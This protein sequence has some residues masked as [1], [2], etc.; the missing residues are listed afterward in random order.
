VSE[1]FICYRR[2]DSSGHA[3]RLLD[4]MLQE[5]GP[6]KVF[7]DVVGIEPGVNFKAHIEEAIGAC[8]VVIV[9]IGTDWLSAADSA[10]EPRLR[11]PRD[12]LRLELATALRANKR[13]IPALV[14][15]ARVPDS[16]DL[17]ED[18]RTLADLS[19]IELSDTRWDYDVSV[20]VSAIKRI[21]HAQPPVPGV[22]AESTP[23]DL[24]APPQDPSLRTYRLEAEAR[25]ALA[26]GV[27]AV[28][29]ALDG[30]LGPRGQF[31]ILR[32]GAGGKSTRR[33]LAIVSAI[34]LGDPVRQ[35]G[36]EL[37]REMA[38]EMQSAAGGGVKTAIVLAREL[39]TRGVEAE[40]DG[41][42]RPRLL[43][44]LRDAVDL[45]AA[46]LADDALQIDDP[47]TVKRIVAAI[48]A[49]DDGGAIAAA[50]ADVIEK[51]GR[52]GVVFVEESDGPGVEVELTEGMRFQSGYVSPYMVTDEERMEAVLDDPYVLI[53]SAKTT[54]VRDLLPVLEAVLALGKPLLI[55]AEDVEGESL[56]TL[57]VNKLRGTFTSVAV[58]A[59]GFGEHRARMLEDIALLTGAEIVGE[60]HAVKLEDTTISQLGRA[61]HVVVAKDATTIVGGAGNRA[62]IAIRTLKIMGELK[63]TGSD[64]EREWLEER[65][66]KLSGGVAIV[67]VGAAT[68]AKL[69]DRKARYEEAIEAATAALDQGVLPGGGAALVHAGRAI[70]LQRY[71][72]P[73]EQ[74]GARIVLEALNAPLGQIASNAGFDAG[75]ALAAVRA[76]GLGSAFDVVS[77]TARSEHDAK[78]PID[79]A[80]IPRYALLHAASLAERILTTQGVVAVTPPPPPAEP[81]TEPESPRIDDMM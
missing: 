18:I 39:V 45:A 43:R 6:G 25:T 59:P 72:G 65:M 22:T 7:M 48:A 33:G 1:V 52:H 62:D 38:A 34:T 37:V 42:N 70:D 35:Q 78:A 14:R 17:P 27:D 69:E 55:I 51:V 21:V 20:L 63:A 12:F 24:S 3:G 67:K 68:G 81:E 49:G 50:V 73:D 76:A 74:A 60:Q 46:R 10:G 64:A 41:R 56:A 32:T 26:E 28:A 66:A 80:G 57:I 11:D 4:R 8:V 40:R 54:A 77:G 29:E 58:K 75:A 71:A 30:T 79:P 5:L 13:V 19:A 61:R 16:D 15:G 9:L 2:D 31:V 47:P 23:T 44:G 53:A 36:V